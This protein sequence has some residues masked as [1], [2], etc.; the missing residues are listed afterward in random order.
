MGWSF[1]KNFYLWK[2]AKELWFLAAFERGIADIS[3]VWSV[4][5]SISESKKFNIKIE[6]FLDVLTLL[7][8][9]NR[10]HYLVRDTSLQ[11][12]WI[13]LKQLVFFTK[14]RIFCHTRY[15][16]FEQ[17]VHFCFQ[18]EE[19]Y[20]TYKSDHF[21]GWFWVCVSNCFYNFLFS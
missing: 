21:R 8:V 20:Y 2:T 17:N 7:R 18:R 5:P 1:N 9:K 15:L 3:L 12:I 14:L 4:C 6:F 13:T 10:E 11:H 16:Y 19:I